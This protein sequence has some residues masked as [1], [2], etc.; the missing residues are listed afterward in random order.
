MFKVELKIV[1]FYD[2]KDFNQLFTAINKFFCNE[3]T[4]LKE[5]HI[6]EYGKEFEEQTVIH[7]DG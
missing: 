1:K 2:A 3:T 7:L 6:E 5:V 4:S